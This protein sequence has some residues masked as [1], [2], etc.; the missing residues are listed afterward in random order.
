MIHVASVVN[1]TDFYAAGR[2]LENL[3]LD[4]MSLEQVEAYVQTGARA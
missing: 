2:T 3:R 1:D 4:G